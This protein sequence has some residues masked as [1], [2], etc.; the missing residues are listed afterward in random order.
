[1]SSTK[2]NSTKKLKISILHKISKFILKW[3]KSITRN[4]TSYLHGCFW[5]N[6]YKTFFFWFY[7]VQ[8]IYDHETKNK[9]KNK[10]KTKR[11]MVLTRLLRRSKDSIELI[12]YFPSHITSGSGALYKLI[13]LNFQNHPRDTIFCKN[14]LLGEWHVIQSTLFNL[15]DAYC[16]HFAALRWA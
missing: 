3:C 10:N 4:E 1:M 2:N 13:M 16:W 7:I 12:I 6:S 14:I 8:N 11:K 5:Y 9:S 15:K